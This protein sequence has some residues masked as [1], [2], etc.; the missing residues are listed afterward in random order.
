[1]PHPLVAIVGRPNVGKSTLFNRILKRQDAVVD[2]QPGVTRDRHYGEAEWDGVRFTL[3]DTGGWA[4]PGEGDALT[5]AVREQTLIAAEEADVVL[6]LCDAQAGP[7]DVER[8]L[9]RLIQKRNA[10]ALLIANKVDDVTRLGLAWELPTLGLGGPYPVSARTGYLVAEML[11]ELVGWLRH[12]KP[13]MPAA[14]EE[15]VLSLA[16]IGAPNSGKSS[17]VNRLAGEKR[18]VVS[19]LPGTT[20]DSVDTIVQYHNKSIRLI[21]TAGLRKRRIDLQGLDFYC[22][23]RALRSIERA[24]VTA[25]LIDAAAGLTQGDIRLAQTAADAGTGVIIAVNKWDLISRQ[26]RMNRILPLPR[27]GRQRLPTLGCANGNTARRA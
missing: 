18:M 27:R 16:I 17:L 24:D 22:T 5:A 6:F 4:P 9:A 23:I 2:P 10:P 8:G 7:S 11:D 21:D 26:A 3:I 15:E 19:D 12:L 25:V 14:P 13:V 1:M 20:R